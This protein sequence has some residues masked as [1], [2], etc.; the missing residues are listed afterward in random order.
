MWFS[1]A[2]NGRRK[3]TEQQL[4]PSDEKR[5]AKKKIK[6]VRQTFLTNRTRPQHDVRNENS[7]PP[8]QMRTRENY[9]TFGDTERNDLK[10]PRKT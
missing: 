1:T 3:N 6:P 5:E 9:E 7:V 4:S 10:N 8:T 2:Y